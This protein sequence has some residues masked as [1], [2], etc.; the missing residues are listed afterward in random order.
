M[1]DQL[2]ELEQRIAFQDDAIHQLNLTVSRQQNELATL[3][4]AIQELQ[5]QLRNLEPPGSGDGEPEIPP[6][7]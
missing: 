2:V 6:H 7:Y 1:N 3:R 5:K 4:L